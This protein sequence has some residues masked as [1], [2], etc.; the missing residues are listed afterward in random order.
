MKLFTTLI[1][2][3]TALTVVLVMAIVANA[4]DRTFA[5]LAEMHADA[6][7]AEDDQ[8]TIT[9]DL[10]IEYIFESYFLLRDK[11]GTATCVNYNYNFKDFNRIRLEGLEEYPETPPVKPG[12]IFKGY[13][14]RFGY[15]SYTTMPLLQPELDM[16]NVEFV[17][18]T[19]E[20]IDDTNYAPTT[21]KTSIRQ[22]LDNPDEY[23]GKVVSLDEAK[24]VYVEKRFATYLVQGEDTLK[25]FRIS[26]LDDSGYP[27]TLIIT[28][29]LCTAKYGGG[30]KLELSQADYIS[31]GFTEIKAVKA[32]ALTENIPLDLTAQV[33]RKEIY[34]GKTYITIMNGEGKYLLNYSGIR[35]LLNEENEVDKTI[36]VGDYINLK[37]S[38]A[39][40]VKQVKKGNQFTLSQLILDEHETAIVSNGV[41]NFLTIAPEEIAM[42]SYYE[43]LPASLN[44]YVTLSGQPTAEQIAHNVSPA[45]LTTIYGDSYPIL[46]DLTY[47]PEAGTRFVVKGILDIP[48]WMESSDKPV[49]TPISEDGFMADSYAF[50]SIADMLE[51]GAPMLD[52]VNYELKNAVT[53]TGIE[54]ILPVGPDDQI[55]NI[56]FVADATGS[57][58][59]KGITEYKVGDAISKVSGFYSGAIASSVSENGIMNFGV[60]NFLALDTTGVELVNVEPEAIEPIEVTIAQLLASDEYASKL[61]KL[62]NFTY[63]KVEEIVQDTIVERC[64]IY[65]GTDSMAVDASFELQE[66]KSVLVG[67]Y[68]L[69]GFY[70]SVI[71]YV[72]TGSPTMLETIAED[73]KLF[74][75]N[76][77][78][79]AQDSAIEVYDVMGRLIATGVDAVCVESCAQSIFVVKTIRLDGVVF[80][81]KV[82]NR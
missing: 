77:T 68:Y 57:L 7:L 51:F 60:S 8:V 35:I 56:I 43:Y 4:A 53:I 14:A 45:L 42:L 11:E 25:N 6:T 37:T 39:R 74:V 76:N 30:C 78:I 29:A 59:L 10:V 31:E 47:M 16:D 46:L 54:T 41:V 21:V 64:F 58:L 73:D 19:A 81:T 63:K 17:G 61:V 49:I 26:G 20:Y 72:N 38:T 34:E 3:I 24:T 48:M 80:V 66:D 33:L 75:A 52:V 50:E 13:T 65:Q 62:T 55:Q 71:P 79:Y 22:L 9:G 67:N 2:R 28:K 69:N 44:G 70:T 82:A 1:Q 23:I 5:T 32:T 18:F 12:D 15:A 27:N 40:L 36:Q